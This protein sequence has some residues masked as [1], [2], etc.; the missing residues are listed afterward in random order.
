MGK[1]RIFDTEVRAGQCW[2]L[3]EGGG[4]SGWVGSSA[5]QVSEVEVG[6]DEVEVMLCNDGHLGK[7]CIFQTEVRAEPCWG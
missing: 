4:E 3:G 7:S 5:R 1:S 2:G 6:Q